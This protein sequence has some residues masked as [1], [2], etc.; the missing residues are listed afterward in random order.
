[1][2][3]HPDLPTRR[4]HGHLWERPRDREG[5]PRRGHVPHLQRNPRPMNGGPGGLSAVYG[6]LRRSQAGGGG[7]GFLEQNGVYVPLQGTNPGDPLNGGYGYLDWTDGGATPHPGSDLNAGSGCNADEGAP[8][9]AQVGG[10]V[11]AVLPWDGWSS[12]EGNHLWVYYD[13]ERAVAP[14][15]SHH[16]HLSGFNV[17]EHQRFEAG[18]L[19]GWCGRTGGWE[20]AH[21]H[22][23][24]LRQ[25]PSSFWL[26]P[27]GWSPAQVQGLYFDPY[28]WTQQTVAKAGEHGGETI[29]ME[30][31]PEEREAMKPYFETYGVPCNPDTAIYQKAALAYKRDESRGPALS[32]EYDATTPD[33]LP[34][35]RQDF[36]AGIAEWRPDTNLVYW[37]EVVKEQGG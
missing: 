29:P 17:M 13:D 9:V 31:T 34:S 30:T 5:L 27:Y 11:V 1:M 35:R 12:G 28:V 18:H 14:A 36:T 26:W 21:D 10:V 20:C 7:G 33:G 8:V 4:T 6:D 3:A 2:R 16:D 23:E 15:W 25:Q 19:L 37:V 24:L 32:P 22:V